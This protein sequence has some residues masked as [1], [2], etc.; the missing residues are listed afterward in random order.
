MLCYVMLQSR[1]PEIYELRTRAFMDRWDEVT[2][3]SFLETICRPGNANSFSTPP[4]SFQCINFLVGGAKSSV[5]TISDVSESCSFIVSLAI[6]FSSSITS[7]R[8]FRTFR[9][10]PSHKPAN[11]PSM[12]CL[13]QKWYNMLASKRWNTHVCTQMYKHHQ[14]TTCFINSL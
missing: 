11:W 10:D 7:R 6:D 8:F 5:L 2:W 12:T 1:F 4:V 14:S 3:D 13:P 9:S